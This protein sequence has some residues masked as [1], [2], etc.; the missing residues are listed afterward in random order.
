MGQ[1][2]CTEICELT[3]FVACILYLN[4]RVIIPSLPPT[5]ISLLYELGVISPTEIG[6]KAK[7]PAVLH[8]GQKAILSVL[9]RTIFRKLLIKV[10]KIHM[11]VRICEGRGI[12]WISIKSL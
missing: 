3:G 2:T 4:I 10:L 5:P 6:I 11:E 8:D 1:Q 7:N 12:F 9:I